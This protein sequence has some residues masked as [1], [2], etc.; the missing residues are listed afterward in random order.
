MEKEISGHK[1]NSLVNQ[2][3]HRA[4]GWIKWAPCKWLQVPFPSPSA[5]LPSSTPQRFSLA[6]KSE[7]MASSIVWWTFSIH[8]Q[9][10]GNREMSVLGPAAPDLEISLR[11]Q[12]VVSW[13][14]ASKFTSN[15]FSNVPAILL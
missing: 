14:K 1:E 11:F 2:N 7:S 13:R 4:E 5:P 10:H 6:V 9:S 15:R 12:G 8:L 3:Q